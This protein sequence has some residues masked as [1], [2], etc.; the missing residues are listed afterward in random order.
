MLIDSDAL[1]GL[2]VSRDAHN[3]EAIKILKVLK[4]MGESLVTSW[5][6]VDETATKLSYFTTHKK[7]NEFLDWVFKTNIKVVYVDD[8]LARKAVKKFKKQTSKRVSLTDCT[9]MVIAE[10]MGVKQIFS[11][12]K[13][14]EQ[15]GLELLK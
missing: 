15:N 3:R 13:H 7:A 5:Q 1:I 6:V 10:E 4:E 9:N 2:R 8:Q 11:F 12:D 14:Y